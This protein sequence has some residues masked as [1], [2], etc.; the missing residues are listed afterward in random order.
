MNA[1]RHDVNKNK[2]KKAEPKQRALV[3]LPAT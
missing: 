3:L 1:Q 2:C